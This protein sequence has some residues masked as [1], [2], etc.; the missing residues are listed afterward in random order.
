LTAALAAAPD[1]SPSFYLLYFNRSRS[2]ALHGG[3][4]GLARGRVKSRARA[5][6]LENLARIQHSIEAQFAANSSR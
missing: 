4:S 3:F 2:D 5:G 1:P 6:A